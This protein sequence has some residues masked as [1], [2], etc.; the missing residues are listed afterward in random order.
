[1]SRIELHNTTDLCTDSLLAHFREGIDGWTTGRMTVRVRHSRSTDFSGS[2]YYAARRIFI[3]VGRHLAYPYRMLTHLARTKTAGRRWYKPA[4]SIELA[5]ANEL[6]VFV[7]MHELYHLLVKKAKRNTRQKESMCDRFA[8]RFLVDRFGAAIHDHRGRA[9]DRGVWDFQDL[10]GFVAAT[11]DGRWGSETCFP[12]VPR[13]V[14]IGAQGLL[15][16]D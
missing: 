4:C 10:D 12:R 15:F 9:V 16:P 8:A 6:V 11:R 7:F 3:N 13:R 14:A 5:D 1:M 2:C